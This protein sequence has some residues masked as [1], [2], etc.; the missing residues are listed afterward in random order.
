M[1]RL[2]ESVRPC[3]QMHVSELMGGT[4]VFE[5]ATCS[6]MQQQLSGWIGKLALLTLV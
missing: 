4:V 5:W 2:N 3:L 1:A 6:L